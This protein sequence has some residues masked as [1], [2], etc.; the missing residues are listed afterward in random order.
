MKIQLTESNISPEPH[1]YTDILAVIDYAFSPKKRSKRLLEC[2]WMCA[3]STNTI[4]DSIVGSKYCRKELK[5]KD[6]THVIFFFFVRSMGWRSKW[7]S[8][9]WVQWDRWWK[10]FHMAWVEAQWEEQQ[11]GSL[12]LHTKPVSSPLPST[13]H[14]SSPSRPLTVS[15]TPTTQTETS[16]CSWI[17]Q[18]IALSASHRIRPPRRPRRFLAGVISTSMSG[19]WSS[20]CWWQGRLWTISTEHS[21]F[22]SVTTPQA[23]GTFR[24]ASCHRPK[25]WSLRSSS[26]SSHICTLTL[27]KTSR[28][29]TTSRPLLTPKRQRHLTVGWSTRKPTDPRSPNP[30]CTTRLRPASRNTPSLTL[31]GS[32]LNPSRWSA[33]SSLS[34]AS[35]TSWFK[36]CVRT[37]TSKVST[38]TLDK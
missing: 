24:S 4:C 5:S 32:V 10:L 29:M 35:T 26:S 18:A 1:I 16:R 11:E 38:L 2:F 9:I 20:A 7:T 23:W 19:P 36:K 8:Q 31:P 28:S 37:T 12:S 22:T 13:R 21:P 15:T 25:W 17:R 14:P 6:E 34:S 33:F 27:S 30:A 3:V